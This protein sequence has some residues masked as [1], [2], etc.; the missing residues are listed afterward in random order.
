MRSALVSVIQNADQFSFD[1]PASS[2]S[3]PLSWFGTLFAMVVLGIMAAGQMKS[4]INGKKFISR[5]I[6]RRTQGIERIASPFGCIVSKDGEPFYNESFFR[7]RFVYRGIFHG[8]TKNDEFAFARQYHSLPSRSCKVYYDLSQGED[9]RQIFF[10]APGG[11]VAEMG[12]IDLDAAKSMLRFERSEGTPSLASD[13]NLRGKY[14]EPEYWFV[15]AILEPCEMPSSSAHVPVADRMNTSKK[16]ASHAELAE[17]F[18]DHAMTVDVVFLDNPH[19]GN[20]MWN[21]LYANINTDFF[22]GAELFFRPVSYIVQ[23]PEFPTIFPAKETE[24]LLFDSRYF[25]SSPR[26]DAFFSA[27]VRLGDTTEEV[28]VTHFSLE[29]VSEGIGAWQGFLWTIVGLTCIQGNRLLHEWRSS[30]SRKEQQ[31]T[32]GTGSACT[33]VAREQRN[34]FGNLLVAG[35]DSPEDRLVDLQNQMMKLCNEVKQTEAQLQNLQIQ[36]RK[37]NSLQL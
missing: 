28:E 13:L 20:F 29:N 25:R 34:E 36:I 35:Q 24:H 26:K 16:C 4:Y 14:G 18:T 15:Q 10:D 3:T 2:L 9:P 11:K 23:N 21:N 8:D 19:P 17:L 31:C 22:L 12:C 27:Y 5:E 33:D 1:Q 7:W 6:S 32:K 30:R 37:N